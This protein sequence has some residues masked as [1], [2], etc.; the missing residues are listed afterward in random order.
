MKLP[1]D[2]DGFLDYRYLT[3]AEIRRCQW[4]G[5]RRHPQPEIEFD[6]AIISYYNT[7][8]FDGPGQE[9]EYLSQLEELDRRQQESWGFASLNKNYLTALKHTL[10]RDRL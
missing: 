1:L 10:V 6:D 2:E 3:D 4:L 5:G 7:N 8:A 9:D